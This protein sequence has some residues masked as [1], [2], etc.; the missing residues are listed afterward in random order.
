MKVL[1]TQ[2]QKYVIH[3]SINS[4][5]EMEVA[6]GKS[7]MELFNEDG[8]SMTVLRMLVYFGLKSKTHGM[9]EERAGEIMSEAIAEGMSFAEISEMFVSELVGSLGMSEADATRPA[10]NV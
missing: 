10:K 4:L 7:F 8:I 1:E 2:T 3:Y 6:T 9:T 5:V